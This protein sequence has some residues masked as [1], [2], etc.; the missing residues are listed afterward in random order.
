MNSQPDRFENLQ[1]RLLK[2][3]AQNRRF[4]QLG[5]AALLIPALLLVMGQAAPNRAVTAQT[6]TAQEFI[7]QESSGTVRARM[8]VEDAAPVFEFTQ[9]TAGILTVRRKGQQG[10]TLIM[11]SGISLVGPE[12][13]NKGSGTLTSAGLDIADGNSHAFILPEEVTVLDKEGF[14]ANLGRVGLQTIAT[15]ETHKTSAA[16]LILFDKDKN[17]I[18]K[19]P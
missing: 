2:L 5:V 3:E 9:G 4:K 15:G 6:V 11:P 19:A 18:W 8:Y 7:L 1:T 10:Y 16:S 13:P 17:V 12:G 14:S